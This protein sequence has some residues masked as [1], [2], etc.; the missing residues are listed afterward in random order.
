MIVTRSE[1]ELPPSWSTAIGRRLF[2]RSTR[3]WPLVLWQIKGDTLGATGSAS[4]C[5]CLCAEMHWQSQWH[6]NQTT[7][8]LQLGGPLATML[9]ERI[10]ELKRQYTGRCVVVDVQRPELARMAGK[11]GRIKTINYNGR[12]LVQFEE[13]DPGW[14]DIDLDYLKVVE[15][16][17]SVPNEVPSATAETKDT[18]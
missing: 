13:S 10:E 11:L 6:P 3:L 14:H 4:A 12:A 18:K 2:E 16:P 9:S 8:Q 5:L 17:Q 1:R 15:P 7:Y